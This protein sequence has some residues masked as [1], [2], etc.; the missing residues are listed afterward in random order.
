M[1][2]EAEKKSKTSENSMKITVSRN[3]PYIVTGR[4]PLI[5]S[6]IHSD[7]EGYCINWQEIK[8]YPLKEKYALCRCGHSGNKPFCDGTHTK[9]HF[10][11]TEKGDYESFS[12]GAIV[13]SGPVLTLKDNKH[14]CVHAEFCLRA[15]GI[16]KLI[17]RSDYPEARDIAIEEAYNCPSGRLVII[18][19]TTGEKIEPEF[20]K[21]IVVVEYPSRNEQGPLWVR[22]GIPVESAD[23]RKYEIRN[24]VTLCRCGKSE[25]KPFCDGS[26]FER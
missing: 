22:G 20:E 3:G 4:V 21:S 1:A 13:V 18:D 8:R 6:E 15:G 24:R 25:N 9:I 14:L 11:G 5:V 7:E 10:D 17:K 26:H 23:G 16:W 2:N 12:E 19:S